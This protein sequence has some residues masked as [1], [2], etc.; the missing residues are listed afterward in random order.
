MALWGAIL[1]TLFSVEGFHM[2]RLYYVILIFV[3]TPH[4]VA[5]LHKRGQGAFTNSFPSNFSPISPTRNSQPIRRTCQFASLQD[6]I[7][8]NGRNVVYYIGM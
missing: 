2:C 5:T 4:A 3:G 1:I 7:L 8:T 6:I